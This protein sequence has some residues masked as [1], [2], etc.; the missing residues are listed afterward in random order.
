M[1]PLIKVLYVDDNPMDRELVRDALEKEQEGFQITEASSRQE[2]EACL[3]EGGFDLVLSDFNI[4]GFEGLQ[5]IEAIKAGYP[6]LPVIIVTGTGSEEIAVEA[7]RSGAADYVIK[8]PR[9]IQRL[10]ITIQA[11]L[12]KR[13]LKAE[14]AR[15]IAELRE[16]RRDWEEIFQAIG[17]PTLILESEYNIVNANRAAC[18]AVGLLEAELRGRKCYEIFHDSQQPP[19]NCP[20]KK[21]LHSGRLEAMEM[22]MNALGGAFIVSCTPVLDEAGRLQKVIHIATDITPRK[23][24]E[25]ALRQSEE[26]YRRLVKQVPAVVYKG[27]RDWGLECFD[28]KIE[29]ITGYSMEEFN[30]RQKTWLDLIFPEDLDQ[31]R[32]SFKEALKGDGSYVAEYRIRKKT[33]EV[34]WLQARNRIVRDTAGKFDYISGVFFDIT[35]RKELEDQ[36]I[37]AQKMEAVGILAGGVAHD[38]NNL[39]TA[40]MG[41]SEMMMMGLRPED[42]FHLY[43]EEITKAVNRGASLTNQLLAFSRKQILQPQV[44]NLNDMVT[45]MD[46]M[47]QRL[48]GEDID[49]VTC[50]DQELGLV[51]A[52]PSQIEQII[53]NL[54]V[55]ARD[56]MPHGGKLTIET[57]N[58]YLDQAYAQGHADATPGPHVMLAVSDNGTGMDTE[59]LSHIFE[60][61]FTTKESG[62][63]TGLGLATIYGVVKQSGGNVWVYSEPGQ[64]T[65]FKVYLPRVE[66][67]LE[68]V[69]PK[70]APVISLEGKETILLVEDDVGLRE[71]I[72]R[73]LRHYGFTVLE[74]AQGG[75][76]LLLCE[77]EKA[78][79]HLMLTDVVMP[80]MSGATLAERLR[81]LHPEMQVLFMSGYTEDA[82]VHHGVLNSD[83]NFI[84]KPFRML[85]L[86][87]KVREVLDSTSS[88]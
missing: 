27:H 9:H 46:K 35:E 78:P 4:L 50:I 30:G 83:V 88:P 6:G 57:A 59:T 34:S 41:Y 68:I 29:E 26:K 51:K 65:T 32:N 80:H 62:K 24:A 16:A 49:L 11:V 1:K 84:P 8:T 21:M 60:P 15:S 55:N 22:E 36:L 2:F 70:T 43:V 20:L 87:Q 71:L 52:D 14:K 69:K 74:A 38:F 10:P 86:V 33:G 23:R 25:E 48:I 82:I 72:S 18:Q 45:D 42:P 75:E 17:H 47:L 19:E 13:H 67:G 66:E 73:A 79:I 81:V 12:E 85:A 44:I 76:A 5:V 64:G 7:M 63:G 61:F 28:Q 31:A 56:A 39:L 3:Q 77:K 54:A 58:V 53:M 37:K 40:I